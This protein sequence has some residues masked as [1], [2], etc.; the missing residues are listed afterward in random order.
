MFRVA[1]LLQSG[2]HF[3]KNFETKEKCEEFILEH[4]EVKRVMIFNKKTGK[5]ENIK[6]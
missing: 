3:A 2:Q 1:I 5:K 6:F 4:R